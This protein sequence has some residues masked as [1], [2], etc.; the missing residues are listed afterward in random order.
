MTQDK[1]ENLLK[2]ADR[3]APPPA[4]VPVSLSA[5]RRRARR[6]AVVR[7]ALCAAAILLIALAILSQSP[8]I[9]KTPQDH[10]KIASLEQQIKQSNK[11]SD[12]P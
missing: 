3:T 9:T 12:G 6:R 1:I 5:I 4:S 8:P 2:Q 7:T 11:S 10:Q